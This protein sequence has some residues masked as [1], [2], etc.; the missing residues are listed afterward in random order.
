MSD[1]EWLG[2]VAAAITSLCWLPQ[3]LK[4]ARDRR[5]DGVSLATN[6]FFAVGVCLWLVYGVLMGAPAV[7]AANGVTLIFIL[8]IVGM[9]LRFG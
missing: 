5:A 6:A 4:I 1:V 2:L 9:K 7:I 3:L 8:L